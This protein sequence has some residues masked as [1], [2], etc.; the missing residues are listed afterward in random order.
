VTH[1]P[2]RSLARLLA[3]YLCWG[4]SIPALKLMVE[5]IPPLGG[6]ALVF[7]AGGCALAVP[8]LRRARSRPAPRELRRAVFTGVLLL[9]GQGLATVGLTEVSASLTAIL[10]AAS[11]LWAALFARLGGLPIDR[12]GVLRLVVGFAGIA[13][14]LLS[15][16]AAAIGGEPIAIVAVLLSSV[17]WGLGTAVA[18]GGALPRDPYVAGALQLLAGGGVLLFLAI[19]FGQTAP[20]AWDGASAESI[21]AA[22]FLLAIDSLAGFLL[23]TSLLRDTPVTVVG[24]YAFVTPVVGAALGLLLLGEQL[25]LLAVLGAAVALTA[26][27]AQLRARPPTLAAR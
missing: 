20:A 16:P 10:I 5:T 7:L 22:A 6:A 17:L 27:G 11:A 1:L 18:A 9:G 12:A 14:V 19:A 26:V 13:V 4:S 21:A 25:S 3:L 24:T 23:Y 8:A 15:A 2:A